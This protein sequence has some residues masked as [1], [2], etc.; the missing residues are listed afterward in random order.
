MNTVALL[1]LVASSGAPG[2]TATAAPFW[3]GGFTKP[4]F[5]HMYYRT[6]GAWLRDAGDSTST[7]PNHSKVASPE[8]HSIEDDHQRCHVRQR[9]P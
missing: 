3:D 1:L 7:T 8:D 6:S 2:P 9:G 5:Y 4:C